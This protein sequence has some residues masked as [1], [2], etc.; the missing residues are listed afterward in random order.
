M[1]AKI[2]GI[3]KAVLSVDKLMLECVTESKG[4]FTLI[5][6]DHGD[7]SPRIYTL[8]NEFTS[9]VIEYLNSTEI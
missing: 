8:I 9:K 4:K 1:K 2:I 3:S 7:L 6:E 5:L